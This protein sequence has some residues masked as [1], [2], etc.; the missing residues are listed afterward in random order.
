MSR[1]LWNEGRVVG[2]SAYEVYV[3]CVLTDNP[4]AEPASEKEWLSSTIA[5]G[6]SMLLR[7]G[8]DILNG[9]H[10]IEVPFPSNS[11]LCAANTIIASL[12]LGSGEVSGDPIATGWA[13]K[14]TD[15]GPLIRNTSESSPSGSTIPPEDHSAISFTSEQIEQIKNYMLVSDGIVIQPGTWTVSG[16]TPY[17]DFHPTLSAVPKL[18]IALSNKVT[19]PFY[20]LLT[21]F[22]NKGVISGTA[23][24]T[25][26]INTSSPADGDFLGP[27][28][29]PWA[30]KVLFNVSPF[31]LQYLDS[32]VYTRSIPADDEAITL[33]ST[34]IIDMGS[35]DPY[36]Y[37]NNHAAY[38]SA[39]Q[40]IYI[41]DIS[42]PKEEAA[43]LT[44]WQPHEDLP[45]ALYGIVIAAEATGTD[46]ISPIDIVA[47]GS[48]K[49][50]N[51][52]ADPSDISAS[53][54][55][56]Q[57]YEDATVG[58]TGFI[59]DVG[60]AADQEQ[61]PAT[62][63]LY[64]RDIY[65]ESIIPVADV[66]KT[67]LFGMLTIRE[68]SYTDGQVIG[69]ILYVE[70]SYP[71]EYVHTKDTNGDD[72]DPTT[73]FS[74]PGD[75]WHVVVDEP[76]K[77]IL[78]AAAQTEIATY[79]YVT[80]T[81]VLSDP[82]PYD[83][84]SIAQ[85][86]RITGKLSPAIQAAC[87]YEYYVGGVLNPIFDT[88]G[89]WEHATMELAHQIPAGEE[90]DYYIVMP[91]TTTGNNIAWPVRKS[92]QMVDITVRFGFNIVVSGNP[93]S[94]AGFQNAASATMNS[95]YLGSWWNATVDPV[96]GMSS[97]YD[98]R[99]ANI[100][101][102][103]SLDN[104]VLHPVVNGVVPEN[105]TGQVY[106]GNAMLPVSGSYDDTVVSVF[107]SDLLS[108]YGIHSKFYDYPLRRF[109]E[110]ALYTDMGTGAPLPADNANIKQ[111]CPI[112][113][114]TNTSGTL[115]AAFIISVTNS[116]STTGKTQLATI[117]VQYQD[118]SNYPVGTVI[119]TGRKEGVALSMTD[120]NGTPYSLEGAT[121]DISVPDTGLTWSHLITALYQD[122][123]LDLLGQILISLRSHLTGAG[124]NYIEFNN[125]DSPIRLYVSNTEPVADDIPDGSVGIGWSGVKLYN[126]GVWS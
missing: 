84:V 11:R 7:V 15:Y 60:D 35:T 49:V 9:L 107:G 56:I 86:K 26:A 36:D 68:L 79:G 63:V 52:F 75:Q 25:S 90:E 121:G 81:T 28:E 14:V 83:G 5:M 10:Y 87:G 30:A 24:F 97:D 111:P 119:R 45:P 108:T 37:Y 80:G 78:P 38:E 88:G 42:I 55:I 4:D 43:V 122:K 53:A 41:T 51:V 12:F 34:S 62:Y 13:S 21:G 116:A 23:G 58:T 48:A 50:Y 126:S 71:S 82:L 104:P 1:I 85:W 3:R 39:V 33:N 110:V 103:D 115:E 74:L 59:R 102:V 69:P 65:T 66:D 16:T 73:A 19:T 77:S 31:M 57:I 117:P 91:G 18:R 113:L 105:S 72:I 44:V 114:K 67:N 32:A 101:A 27:W 95:K 2:Y 99:W 76:L 112:S 123:T 106:Y 22:T 64:Q 120:P 93:I 61:Y 70:G 17:K 96:T 109:L 47:P 54:G 125:G 8:T 89:V 46:H 94:L 100:D 124:D 92:D 40:D 29:F 118:T 6:S 98:Y 20:I